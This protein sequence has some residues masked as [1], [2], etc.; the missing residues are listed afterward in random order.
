MARTWKGRHIAVL[1]GTCIAL[2]AF[3]GCDLSIFC[4]TESVAMVSVP[5]GLFQMGSPSGVGDADEQPVH[6]VALTGFRM[7]KYEVTQGQY[8]SVTGDSPSHFNSGADAP[9][10]PVEMV[11]WYDAVEFCNRLSVADGFTPVYTIAGRTPGSGYPIIGGTVTQDMTKNGYRLPTEAE[12]EYAARGGDG[13]PSDYIYSGSEDVGTVAWY[14]GNSG[15]TT[16]AVGT[17]MPNRLGLYDMSGNILEWCQDRYD[18]GYYAM[19]PSLDPAAGASSG[20]YRVERGGSYTYEAGFCRS[21]FRNYGYAD[22]GLGDSGG[23][24]VVRR[25]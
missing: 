9:M 18:P 12:W 23:F 21:A 22:G 25:P 2:M 3:A 6:S 11:T 24:R 17:K 7:G 19:S 16:H 14:D 13:S 20:E 15:S 1:I 4:E 8:L 10:R 5:G